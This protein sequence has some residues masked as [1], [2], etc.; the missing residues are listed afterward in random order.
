M[1]SMEPS[2]P[3]ITLA[4]GMLVLVPVVVGGVIA[5]KKPPSRR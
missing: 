2:S 3:G 5:S 4:C 1:T